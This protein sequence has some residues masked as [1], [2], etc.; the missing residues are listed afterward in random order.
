LSVLIFQEL[1]RAPACPG[2]E[3]SKKPTLA[4]KRGEQKRSSGVAEVQE[5]TRLLDSIGLISYSSSQV[6]FLAIL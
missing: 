6:V 2:G 5:F 4:E 3:F 1:E